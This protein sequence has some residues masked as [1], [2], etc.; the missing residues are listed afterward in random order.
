V[1]SPPTDFTDEDLAKAL[2]E[3]WHVTAS[4]VTYRSVGFGSHHWSV[5]DRTSSAGSRRSGCPTR[6]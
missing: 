1:L 3:H 6:P 5:D 4:S 2:A